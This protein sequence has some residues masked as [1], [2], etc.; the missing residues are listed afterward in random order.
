MGNK[1]SWN[2]WSITEVHVPRLT[3]KIHKQ[4]Y[5]FH[6]GIKTDIRQLQEDMFSYMAFGN[7]N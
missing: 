1:R 7:L 2:I 4:N 5:R 6:P 3:A